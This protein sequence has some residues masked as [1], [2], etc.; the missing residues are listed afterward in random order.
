MAEYGL[1]V[2][3]VA[4]VAISTWVLFGSNVK[5]EIKYIATCI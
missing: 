3:L 5:T 1:M 2:A 4:I